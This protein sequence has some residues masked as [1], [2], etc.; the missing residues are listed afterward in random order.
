MPV[1]GCRH[2]TDACAQYGAREDCI[3]CK[4]KGKVVGGDWKGGGGVFLFESV[5]DVI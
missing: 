5:C 4:K 1:D 3:V 2:K